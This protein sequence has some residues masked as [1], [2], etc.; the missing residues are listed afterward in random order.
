MR[1]GPAPA[2]AR[3][4][5]RPPAQM[6]GRSPASACRQRAADVRRAAGAAPTR[7]TPQRLGA[8][9]AL[10]MN[11]FAA[12][13]G[14]AS[15]LAFGSDCPVTPLDPW[16]AVRAAAWH[17]TA[18]E[19]LTGAGRR[20]PRTPAAAGAPRAATRAACSPGAPPASRSGTSP[21]TSS[22]DADVRIAAWSTDPG[23]VRSLPTCTPT[24][25]LPTCVLTLVAGEVAF[26]AR[27]SRWHDAAQLDPEAGPRPG[28]RPPGPVAGPQGRPADRRPGPAAHHGVG[29]A[30]GAAAGRARRAPTPTASRGS[31]GSSTPSAA[32][33]GLEHGVALPVWDAL[34]PRRGRRPDARWPRRRPPARCGS[35]LP[36][37]R[38]ADAAPRPAARRRSARASGASTRRRARAGPADRAVRRP[39]AQAV[40]LPDRR[41]RR[42]LRGHPAGA[43]GG[44]GGRRR[45]RG[46]PVDRAVAA[47]LRARGRDPRGLRRHLRH[48]GEL[49]ADAGGARRVVARSSAATS[50]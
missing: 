28:D 39:A 12:M 2:R 41:D 1:A 47:R 40:D 50:G 35:A 31:T 43:G 48:P 16:A 23:R 3:R 19:R 30:G 46:D 33:V 10:A 29:R 24:C 32:D 45:H 9:R 7:C 27:R 17:H 22:C 14:P 6:A 5:G 18:S 20:S 36:E 4:D 21:A 34:R 37:G 15:P 44:P 8:D 26:D 42:H 13:H 38:D 25:Q 49:P 11:P